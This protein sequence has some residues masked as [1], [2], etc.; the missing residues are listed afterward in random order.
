MN[1]SVHCII[2]RFS[3]R[4]SKDD[5]IDPL[6]SEERLNHRLKIFMKYCWPSIINQT[7]NNFYWII[8][9]DPLLPD[10]YKLYLINLIKEFY[11][12][13]DYNKLGPRQIILH[14]WDWDKDKLEQIDWILNYFDSQSIPKYLITT[15]LDDDDAL[16]KTLVKQIQSNL[17]NKHEKIT[18]F[19]YLSYCY[20]YYYYSNS[21]N[22]KAIK[23]PLIALGLSLITH[24]KKWP[25]CVYL[26]SHTK[27][28]IYLQTCEKN[29][30]FNELCI[31]N[32]QQFDMTSTRLKIIKTNNASPC[33]VRT[34]HGYNL[35]ENLKK[36]FEDQK[37][38]RT[39]K[40]QKSLLFNLFGIDVDLNVNLNINIDIKYDKIQN[41]QLPNEQTPNEKI[42][43]EQTTSNQTEN[44]QPTDNQTV[45]TNPDQ[46][47][48]LL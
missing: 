32:K 23:K 43:N 12:S 39:N 16:A 6:L 28:P 15:R 38:N 4:F 10:K 46:T 48:S 36:L 11:R 41:D 1:N 42:Q 2:T 33:W 17:S 30:Y 19:L 44:N 29:K 37:T 13:A 26:G 31:K 35:Q 18:D 40:T 9:I 27:I 3:Y 24:I 47:T 25:M 34:I 7:S 45:N 21:H 5:P 14:M 20:G 22:L 8:I